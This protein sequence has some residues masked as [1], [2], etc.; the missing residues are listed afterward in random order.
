MFPS[1]DLLFGFANW[2]GDAVSNNAGIAARTLQLRNLLESGIVGEPYI[3]QAQQ[4]LTHALG[5]MSMHYAELGACDGDP[6][7]YVTLCVAGEG[8]DGPGVGHH[9]MQARRPRMIFDVA[10]E[11]R[12][13]RDQAVQRLKLRSLL[14]WP[15]EVEQ[16]RYVLTLASTKPRATFVSKDETAY[17]E[18][19]IGLLTQVLRVEEQ[20]A[21]VVQLATID[22]L[23]GMPNRAAVLDHLTRSIHAAER[24]QQRVAV[25]YIDLDGFKRVNDE[26]GH[27]AGDEAL[28]QIAT[29][30][31]SVLRKNEMC[32]RLGGDEFCAIVTAFHDEEDLHPIASRMLQVFRAPIAINEG[33]VESS[34]SI[35]IAVYPRDGANA[36]ELIAHADRAMYRAKRE[37][38][39]AVTFASDL[40]RA[41]AA[42]PTALTVDAAHFQNE[43]VLCYQPIVSARTGR[44]IAAEVLPRWLK[45]G[46]MCT[47]DVFLRMARDQ[48]T[49]DALDALVFRAAY[50]RL[51][52]SLP[53]ARIT[54]HVNIDKPNEEILK[55]S[56]TRS[57]PAALE[58]SAEQVASQPDEYR[59]YIEACRAHGFYV[60]LAHFGSE[61]VSLQ[62]FL[63]L[64]LDFVKVSKAHWDPKLI[65]QAQ[66]MGYTVIAEGV[67]TVVDQRW[68]SASGADALQGFAIESPLAEQDFVTWMARYNG[69]AFE[70][71]AAFGTSRQSPAP[72]L[73][74]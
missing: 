26:H 5:S 42:T 37:T 21:Q 41:H 14:F 33:M 40:E 22:P 10:L 66:R 59:Q 38:G 64:E 48:G 57:L 32:G 4:L 45:H 17:V 23:T 55:I 68:L 24:E 72:S 16:R 70:R 35:G 28:R 20:Q 6:A 12:L 52:S 47:P 65:S 69:T 54:L 11:E 56:R 49:I 13:R 27:A 25:F 63:Q 31:Q 53:A 74:Q 9:G 60:G 2:L 19:L 36:N 44:V 61:S 58:F 43:F 51:S 67:E 34:A 1:L 71:D 46:S 62:T 39:G 29:R 15:F 18:I 3:A 8:V 7:A 30:L 73:I 50:E